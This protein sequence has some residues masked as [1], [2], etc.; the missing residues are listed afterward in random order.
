MIGPDLKELVGILKIYAPVF[1]GMDDDK[2][3][4]IKNVVILLGY[5]KGF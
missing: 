3:F 2:K 4:L 5:I 1:K